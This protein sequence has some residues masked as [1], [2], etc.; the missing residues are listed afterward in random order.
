M[1]GLLGQ[2][3]IG[4]RGRVALECGFEKGW[5]EPPYGRKAGAEEKGLG[6]ALASRVTM[7][8]VMAVVE[9]PVCSVW[10]AESHW[11][12]W[13]S[14]YWRV[15]PLPSW[16]CWCAAPCRRGEQAGEVMCLH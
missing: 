10:G 7:E 1:L 14:Y 12:S 3:R 8:K 16:V 15:L 4:K 13:Q 9:L 6:L 11:G 2:A 5:I